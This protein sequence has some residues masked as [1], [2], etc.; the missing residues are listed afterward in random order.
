LKERN[1]E[2][3]DVSSLL[4]DLTKVEDNGTLKKKHYIALWR[5]GFGKCYVPVTEQ[6]M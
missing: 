1:D 5:N 6:T 2:E 4:D 3:L